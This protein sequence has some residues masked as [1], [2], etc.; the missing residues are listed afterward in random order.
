MQTSP[1]LE[2]SADEYEAHMSEPQV[3]QRQALDS[4]MADAMR[5]LQPHSLL[6]A[7]CGPGGGWQHIDPHVT[8]SVT[9]VDIHPGYLERIRHTYG[10]RLAGLRLLCGDILTAE[11][12][13][14]GY[15]LIIA[16]LL[17]EYLDVRAGLRRMRDLL[18]DDGTLLAVLQLQST[19]PA[20]SQTP[21]ASIRRLSDV[22]KLVPPETFVQTAAEEGLI[23]QSRHVVAL[24]GEK[25]FNV[26]YFDAES[27]VRRS[28]A[29]SN[30]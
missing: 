4:I 12:P 15:D 27:S 3:G 21:Y 8:G 19:K 25:A 5:R 1:W 23:C 22:M 24:P 20:V 14:A 16:A 13:R 2:I 6:V 26:L 17:F 30:D 11:L 10:Q 9:G 7:G 18:K 29:T 28:V